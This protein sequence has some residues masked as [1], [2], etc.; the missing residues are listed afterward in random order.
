M[1]VGGGGD[2]V[3]TPPPAAAILE[4]HPLTTTFFEKHIITVITVS[5]T[6]FTYGSTEGSQ[7]RCLC[8]VQSKMPAHTRRKQRLQLVRQARAVCFG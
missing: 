1:V 7:M 5:L 2:A 4:A 6:T 3:C 8:Q